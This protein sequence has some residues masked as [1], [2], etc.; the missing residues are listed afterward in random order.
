MTKPVLQR[1]EDIM[2]HLDIIRAWKDPEYRLS[3]SEAERA[4]LP[5]HPAG[6]ICELDPTELGQV[7]GGSGFFMSVLDKVVSWVNE[8]NDG[9][10]TAGLVTA[11]KGIAAMPVIVTLAAAVHAE[12]LVTGH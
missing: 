7:M 5:A 10:I 2:T 3:L 4:L 8:G 1:K 12:H 9:S 11:G 6:L